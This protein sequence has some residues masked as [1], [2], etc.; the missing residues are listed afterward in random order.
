M[1]IYAPREMENLY[2]KKGGLDKE[3]VLNSVWGKN[4]REAKEKVIREVA[5]LFADKFKLKGVTATGD[6]SKVIQSLRSMLPLKDTGK[7]MNSK[8]TTQKVCYLIADKLNGIF[9]PNF[10]DTEVD[11]EELCKD[12]SEK[13]YSLTVSVNGEF[14]E[15]LSN[16][17]LLIKNLNTLVEAAEYNFKKI[18]NINKLDGNLTYFHEAAIGALKNI[19]NNLSVMVDQRKQNNFV[20]EMERNESIKNYFKNFSGKYSESLANLFDSTYYFASI[21]EKARKLGADLGIQTDKLKAIA[22]SPNPVVAL[23]DLVGAKV[24][25]LEGKDLAEYAKSFAALKKIMSMENIS[26]IVGRGEDLFID[27]DIYDPMSYASIKNKDKKT[28]TVVMFFSLFNS[29]LEKINGEVDLLIK[30]ADEGKIKMYDF[31][32]FGEDIKHSIDIQ[33]YSWYYKMIGAFS[34]NHITDDSERDVVLSQ[35]AEISARH[36][37]LYATTK[38][39]H[40]LN[41]SKLFDEISALI[42]KFSKHYRTTYKGAIDLSSIDTRIGS[43]GERVTGFIKKTGK[44]IGDVG[45]AVGEVITGKNEVTGGAA[46]HIDFMNRNNPTAVLRKFANLENIILVNIKKKEILDNFKFAWSNNEKF[47]QI[48]GKHIAEIKNDFVEWMEVDEQIYDDDSEGVAANYKHYGRTGA[49]WALLTA[50]GATTAKTGPNTADQIINMK[51]V[52]TKKK[53]LLYCSRYLIPAARTG[54]GGVITHLAGANNVVNGYM[55]PSLLCVS[56]FSQNAVAAT[57]IAK[58]YIK[59]YKKYYAACLDLLE[60]AE[61]IEIHFNNFINGV[62]ENGADF[63]NILLDLETEIMIRR[64][65]VQVYSF[66]SGPAPKTA[67]ANVFSEDN[68]NEL[69]RGTGPTFADTHKFFTPD[70]TNYTIGDPLNTIASTKWFKP[71]NNAQVEDYEKRFEKAYEVSGLKN[72]ISIFAKFSGWKQNGFMKSTFKSPTDISK[73]FHDFLVYRQFLIVD[74]RI[75][76][77][78]TPG[79]PL[80]AHGYL[81]GGVNLEAFDTTAANYPVGDTSN[82]RGLLGD[83]ALVSTGVAV[84]RVDKNNYAFV[85]PMDYLETNT[86]VA[87]LPFEAAFQTN[88]AGAKLVFTDAE[89]ETGTNK[90]REYYEKMNDI[91]RGCVNGMVGKIITAID[92]WKTLNSLNT[93]SYGLGFSPARIIMGGVENNVKINPKLAEIYARVHLLLKLYEQLNK[94]NY[95][96]AAAHNYLFWGLDTDGPFRNLY[97]YLQRQD[98]SESYTSELVSICNVLYEKFKGE[99]DP[100]LSVMRFV[101]KDFNEKMG[102]MSSRDFRNQMQESD[103]RDKR[104]EIFQTNNRIL[105]VEDDQY[106]KQAPSRNYEK[107]ARL[108]DKNTNALKKIETSYDVGLMYDIRRIMGNIEKGLKEVVANTTKDKISSFYVGEKLKQL[109]DDLTGAKEPLRLLTKFFFDSNSFVN[110]DF[111]K[112]A[113]TYDVVD[114]P[115]KV[116]NDLVMGTL[117]LRW[118]A[119]YRNLFTEFARNNYN[120]F[121]EGT[122]RLDGEYDFYP[123][124]ALGQYVHPGGKGIDVLLDL[125]ENFLMK[126][127]NKDV[128]EPSVLTKQFLSKAKKIISI[129]RKHYP[130]F[131]DMLGDIFQYKHVVNGFEFLKKKYPENKKLIRKILNFEENIPKV[132]YGKG[133]GTYA[134]VNTLIMPNT[135]VFVSNDKKVLE[136]CFP[137]QE[138]WP[139]YLFVDVAVD[140]TAAIWQFYNGITPVSSFMQDLKIK[141]VTTF[142]RM[143]KSYFNLSGIPMYPSTQQLIEI[144]VIAHVASVAG[145]QEAGNPYHAPGAR[146][147]LPAY[148]DDTD[149]FGLGG[150]ASPLPGAAPGVNVGI[151][152]ITGEAA[153]PLLYRD[154]KNGFL[155]EITWQTLIWETQHYSAVGWSKDSTDPTITGAAVTV[156]NF[157]DTDDTIRYRLWSLLKQS[158]VG[159][160]LLFVAAATASIRNPI[161]GG[162]MAVPRTSEDLLDHRK[163]RGFI[164]STQRTADFKGYQNTVTPPI[165]KCKP[166]QAAGL[167]GDPGDDSDFAEAETG[168]PIFVWDPDT[169]SVIR[170]PVNSQTAGAALVVFPN[171]KVS[172]LRAALD[173][174]LTTAAGANTFALPNVYKFRGGTG[175]GAANA[176][177]DTATQDTCI[178]KIFINWLWNDNVRGKY[179]NYILNY[180]LANPVLRNMGEIKRYIKQQYGLDFT[181]DELKVDGVYPGD[182]FYPS[183]IGKMQ[184]VN[185]EAKNEEFVILP[186]FVKP[187]EMLKIQMDYTIVKA[188]LKTVPA[189][190]TDLIFKTVAD[191]RISAMMSRFSA[192][193]AINNL[194]TIRD[195]IKK[196]RDSE[197]DIRNYIRTVVTGAAMDHGWIGAAALVD[198]VD[199][200]FIATTADENTAIPDINTAILAGNNALNVVANYFMC[201]PTVAVGGN[202]WYRN[203]LQAGNAR[204]PPIRFSAEIDGTNAVLTSIV[205]LSRKAGDTTLAAAYREIQFNSCGLNAWYGDMLE[206]YGLG[207]V[208]PQ[209]KNIIEQSKKTFNDILVMLEQMEVE[210]IEAVGEI[211]KFQV[212]S[213]DAFRQFVYFLKHYGESDVVPISK[214]F[215]YAISLDFDKEYPDRLVDIYELIYTLVPKNLANIKV[216]G[217]NIII[218]FDKFNSQWGKLLNLC[219]N[220][221]EHYFKL[222][223]VLSENPDFVLEARSYHNALGAKAEIPEDTYVN[224]FQ[225]FKIPDLRD[226]FSYL[227]TKFF[228]KTSDNKS[229]AAPV[230][231]KLSYTKYRTFY[232]KL[233]DPVLSND[234]VYNYNGILYPYLDKG[235]YQII[236]ESVL[237]NPKDAKGGNRNNVE[238]SYELLFDT[239]KT[240]IKSNIYKFKVDFADF[241]AK[242]E[243]FKS[244]IFE[245]KITTGLSAELDHLQR[246]I[247][248]CMTIGKIIDE[249]ILEI[250]ESPKSGELMKNYFGVFEKMSG[251]QPFVPFGTI[252]AYSNQISTHDLAASRSDL[253]YAV[254]AY[255]H[256]E[257]KLSGFGTLKKEMEALEK[258]KVVKYNI[259][260]EEILKSILPAY[261]DYYLRSH[262]F[263]RLNH[264]VSDLVIPNVDTYDI[265][266]IIGLDEEDP[267]SKYKDHYQVIPRK[268]GLTVGDPY[269]EQIPRENITN[270]SEKNIVT[271]IQEN[272]T[273]YAMER[274]FAASG[275]PLPTEKHDIYINLI[276]KNFVPINFHALYRSAAFSGIMLF[277]T[278]FRIFVDTAGFTIPAAYADVGNNFA[279]HESALAPVRIFVPGALNNVY[280]KDNKKY[281]APWMVENT[282]VD[283]F[284]SKLLIYSLNSRDGIVRGVTG[285]FN[286]KV[287]PQFQDPHQDTEKISQWASRMN[288][289]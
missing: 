100:C 25:S 51:K 174:Q 160:S 104:N 196:L 28:E 176:T 171:P 48:K 166:Y 64:N 288:Y 14:F 167:Q 282:T 253:G 59:Y 175:A 126:D 161:F 90:V 268:E 27:K 200:I 97:R 156:G 22:K 217:K 122:H 202:N 78:G 227:C 236:K 257:T 117:Q 254:R 180:G 168:Y 147:D 195:V 43:F 266:H 68:A 53:G 88:P 36:K 98:L 131:L 128:K 81:G 65:G 4:R 80:S 220:K 13:I 16:A 184:I 87:L 216:L 269:I 181:N 285:I 83:E 115:L 118:L 132:F 33:N 231:G 38:N 85:D 204:S 108:H 275:L 102:F 56:L 34:E 29:M 17:A 150:A 212:N 177:A 272:N 145:Y 242:L 11:V 101:S 5:G 233:L 103:I 120:H 123:S 263:G 245:F 2:E 155:S 66:A 149:T 239:V 286:E 255:F 223:N 3:P 71:E 224:Y 154:A 41:I 55:H 136:C 273:K 226:Q 106:K 30:D 96:S 251:S 42:K 250:N 15:A 163:Y 107:Y 20:E 197:I 207:K 172:Q 124:F 151:R 205:P 110:A 211:P 188:G 54:G 238:D 153:L 19:A 193:R 67:G 235:L 7:L 24:K 240:K 283:Q 265:T 209:M 157:N 267:N 10:I 60:T 225:K 222:Q 164:I 289:L 84:N 264:Y 73:S 237:K 116:I 191:L 61:A 12:V 135:A 178:G 260:P 221:V 86:N 208:S 105:E 127:W 192:A 218:N 249:V 141:D 179:I 6:I 139:M 158:L 133:E 31:R 63:S 287:I 206:S 130:K 190:G 229:V 113:G 138:V 109:T 278:V 232:N 143:V 203:N 201:L 79:G 185:P 70:Y 18:K 144:D 62:L 219:N 125:P 246:M 241:N 121:P 146:T 8:Q 228:K 52:L 262:N 244:I 159:L 23:S 252:L 142:A 49:P 198:V 82:I 170:D 148:Y 95:N 281:Y 165:N 50:G 26:K 213:F 284:L 89:T 37:N 210:T 47:E 39:V 215:S 99:S 114:Q 199:D 119:D 69:I 112:Q 258:Y 248:I 261:L 183:F 140:P 46:D 274:F 279:N 259:K 44:F 94:E 35:I 111:Y 271:V 93:E 152:S 189:V 277:D 76:N 194:E 9:G 256:P 92:T 32:Q 276:E 91:F 137:Q 169:A 230:N 58:L 173:G 247:N 187:P 72:L 186:S 77:T 243:F 270:Y 162:R 40:I 21:L 182:D 129:L 214:A 234:F 74:K 134:D 1:Q 280:L 57:N 45:N 75:G